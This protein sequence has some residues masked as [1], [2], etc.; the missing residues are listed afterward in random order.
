LEPE[1]A[2]EAASKYLSASTTMVT[3]DP[4]E[5]KAHMRLTATMAYYGLSSKPDTLI[6]TAASINFV[7]KEF[8]MANGFK[9]IL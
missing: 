9:Q 5:A 1:A 8:V 4:Y 2:I 7:R 3:M 6:D